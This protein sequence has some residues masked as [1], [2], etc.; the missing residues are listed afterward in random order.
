MTQIQNFDIYIY[1]YISE[2][3]HTNHLH[4]I[5]QETLHRGTQAH[6]YIAVCLKQAKTKPERQFKIQK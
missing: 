4:V 2:T 5:K 6:F 1:I 3:K